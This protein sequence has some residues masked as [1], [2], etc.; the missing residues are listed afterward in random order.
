MADEALSI[1]PR[2]TALIIVDMQNDFCHRDGFYARNAE[3]MM[4]IGLDP[5]LVMARIGPMKELLTASRD[6]GLF[7]VHTQIVRELDASNKV[8]T[9]HR[10]VPLTYR[11]YQD[12]PDG[13]PLVPGSWGAATH[14]ELAPLPGEHVLVKRAFSSFYQTDLETTLRRR[15]MRTIILAGTV[16]YVCVLHT[17]FDASVR[18]FD[19]IMASDGVASWAPEL[20]EP[21]LRM[22]NLVIGATLPTS[23]IAD[24]LQRAAAVS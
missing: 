12:A 18:D 22:V 17:A 9:L 20:Q 14:D 21:A 23:E 7:I 24:L 19:V 13:P 8:E 10:I 16:T 15:G 3:R 6:A 2:E 1:T 11:A 5:D 4:S